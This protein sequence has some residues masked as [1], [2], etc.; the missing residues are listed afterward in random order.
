LS[1]D[2]A[3]G[4]HKALSDDRFL[5][6]PLENESSVSGLR[7]QQDDDRGNDELVEVTEDHGL[8]WNRL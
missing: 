3:N 8:S 6:M 4:R 5:N 2:D 7:R 1:T